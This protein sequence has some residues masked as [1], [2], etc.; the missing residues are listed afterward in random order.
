[1]SDLIKR[2]NIEQPIDPGCFVGDIW[3]G[4]PEYRTLGTH[5]WDGKV[6]LVLP[7]VSDTLCLLL[8]KARNRIEELESES[9]RLVEWN[10]QACVRAETA[11]DRIEQL[12]ADKRFIIE[13]RDRTFALM[14][15]RAEAA[16]AKLAAVVDALEWYG[17]QARLCRLI[18]S[19][20]D[21]G[22]NALS[23][24]GG[25]KARDAIRALKSTNQ[26]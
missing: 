26:P 7:D 14:L 22:R 17:E 21:S 13:E 9:A 16:E 6:W 19:E 11:E 23:K 15:A 10:G 3:Y 20:G 1:M 8:A 4:H 24:D 5:R 12:E 18:H 25:E 2:D